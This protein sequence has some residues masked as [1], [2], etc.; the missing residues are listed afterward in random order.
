VT[1]K[2]DA[3]LFAYRLDLADAALEG[4][5]S[6]KRFMEPKRA[7]FIRPYTDVIKS[8][9]GDA[10]RLTQALFGEVAKVFE[11]KN[12]FAWVQLVD[13]SYVGYVSA[14]ALSS[15]V[16]IPTHRVA[17]SSTWAF[18]KANLKTRPSMWL[19]LNA[20]VAVKGEDSGY[21]QLRRGGFVFTGH[22]QPDAQPALGRDW[23]AIAE[24]FIGIPYLWGGKTMQGL[25]C[26]GLVQVA[27][28]SFGIEC[29]RDADMQEQAMG[30][31][32]P[33]GTPLQRGDL[34]FWNGHVGIMRDAETLLHANG[35]HMMTVSEPLV[36]AV[37][38]IAAK[39]F[40]VTSRKR[41][42]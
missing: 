29:P 5:V 41:L 35:F 4:R 34:I 25:D 6:A 13:D 38:R 22:L 40:P 31:E 17:T 11:V 36:K 15:T 28:E 39:G 42:Q 19:P 8:P 33:E 30:D 23:V 3:R 24:N 26:S 10:A 18:A 37:E 7:Q 16:E 9:A 2:L 21:S 20:Q 27:L 12:D 1:E 32:V 14:K